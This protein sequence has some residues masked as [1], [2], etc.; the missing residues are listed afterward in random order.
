MSLTY[1]VFVNGPPPRNDGLL[2]NRKPKTAVHESKH[3]A[4]SLSVRVY[5]G[6]SKPIDSV[7]SMCRVLGVTVRRTYGP[8]S[9]AKTRRIQW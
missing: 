1:D 8:R 4:S 5:Q 9:L 3:R 2:P 6:A 7:Q